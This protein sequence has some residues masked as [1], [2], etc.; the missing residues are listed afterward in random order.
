[1][2]NKEYLFSII[3][4]RKTLL[5]IL[6]FFFLVLSLRL[7]A[8]AECLIH[9]NQSFYV[10][11]EVIWY[12]LYLPKDFPE[13]QKVITVSLYDQSNKLMDQSYLQKKQEQEVHGYYKIPYDSPSNLYQLVFTATEE[14]S[15]RPIPLAHITIPIYND[16]DELNITSSPLPTP[17]SPANVANKLDDL[18][19]TIN[20]D[21][22][23][24]TPRADATL[25]VQVKDASGRPVQAQFSVSVT[26]Q[27]LSQ[28]ANPLF[29]TLQ[30]ENTPLTWPALDEDIS[31]RGTMYEPDGQSIL[32][33]GNIGAYLV[34]QKQFL[35]NKAD[36]EGRFMLDLPAIYGNFSIHVGG[37]FPEDLLVSLDQTS[38]FVSPSSMTLPYPPEV[39][40]YLE[41]SRKRKTIY[42]LYGLLENSFT[43]SFPLTE[44]SIEAADSPISLDEYNSFTD[45][46]TLVKELLIPIRFRPQKDGTYDARIF[47]PTQTRR[48]F[49]TRGPLF[50]LDGKL[51]R[52][53][54]YIAGLDINKIERF[55]LYYVF[56]KGLRLFGPMARSGIVMIKSRNRDVDVPLADQEN[57][58]EIYG[59]QAEV[60]YPIQI[61]ESENSEVLLRPAL[62]WAPHMATNAQGEASISIPLGDDHTRFRIEVVT[63]G[64]DGQRGFGVNSFEV[65]RED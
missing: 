5:P 54:N 62:Y 32:P 31:L 47:D 3:K 55:D 11:G 10:S 50:I 45:I 34:N 29:S 36:K 60:D 63:Q 53:A 48:K 20:L 23:Q 4:D 49:H 1:M 18:Q 64:Q 6:T 30:A 24:Y 61:E 28:V 41:W 13:G 42:Q 17:I 19:V 9:L 37:F 51:T 40:R 14:E 33:S 44:E 8:Q 21:S 26:D 15:N 22:D 58:F 25:Q 38:P 27:H 65:K 57:Y 52:D 16:F 46:P 2:K 7:S 59:F 35:Y 12:K 56:E 43:A 39:I